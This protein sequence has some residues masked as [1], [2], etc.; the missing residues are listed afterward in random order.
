VIA[1]L[2]SGCTADP[3]Y[4]EGFAALAEFRDG[5]CCE[6]AYAQIRASAEPATP[7]EIYRS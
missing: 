3:R 7:Q 4:A 5:N 1:L 2:E 6:R